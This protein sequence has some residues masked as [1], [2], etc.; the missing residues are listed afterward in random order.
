MTK[1]D[2]MSWENVGQSLAPLQH[3]QED[4]VLLSQNIYFVPQELSSCVHGGIHVFSL[5]ADGVP[6]GSPRLE[7]AQF[8]PSWVFSWQFT[9]DCS[10]L[11]KT[12][13]P[14]GQSTLS[15]SHTYIV[16]LLLVLLSTKPNTW[17][18]VMFPQTSPVPSIRTPYGWWW[19]MKEKLQVWTL[20][21]MLL[22]TVEAMLHT[23]LPGV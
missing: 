21:P 19:L 1:L 23:P 8:C 16:L 2:S 18:W 9:T 17:R 12:G 10:G 15:P 5:K 6:Q 7:H 20:S 13:G 3:R 4:A 14:G 11:V 22:A